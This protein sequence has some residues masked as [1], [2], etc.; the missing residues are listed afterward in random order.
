MLFRT[1]FR[2]L[3]L[4]LVVNINYSESQAKDFYHVS[5]RIC[6]GNGVF[7]EFEAG[8]YL[9]RV[10]EPDNRDRPEIWQGPICLVRKYDNASCVFELSLIKNIRVLENGEQIEVVV[11]SGSNSR[12][13]FINLANCRMVESQGNRID[14]LK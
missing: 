6:N 12:L 9:V 7:N 5:G 8:G 3:I 4:L 14:P 13:V 1:F 11:F 10:Y 2:I